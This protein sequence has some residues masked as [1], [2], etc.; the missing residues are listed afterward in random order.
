[1]SSTKN[2]NK[3]QPK[4]TIESANPDLV[5]Q[6]VN[7][8]QK[9]APKVSDNK[10]QPRKNKPQNNQRRGGQKSM[11]N[12]PKQQSDSG[13]KQN[14]PRQQAKQ[15]PRQQQK[16]QPKQQAKQQ[17]KKQ[18]QQPKQSG[19]TK[20]KQQSAKRTPAARQTRSGQS[21]SNRRRT[22]RAPKGKLKIIP[23]GGLGEVGKNLTYY[24]YGNDAFII[25]CGLAFPDDAMPGIDIVIPDF[26]YLIENQ[27]K[28]RGL[29][30]THGHEDHIG[31]IPYLLKHF[32]LPIYGTRLTIGLVEGKLKEH[33]LLRSAKLNVVKPGDSIK[34]GPMTAEFIRVNHSIPDAC[35]IAVHTPAGII[36]HT[37]DFKVDFT[38]IGGEVIDLAR[39]GELGSKGVL[40]LLSDST[41]AEREGSSSSERI[42]GGSLENFFGKAEHKRIIVATFAS[43]VH[44]IQQ[45]MDAAVKNSRKVAVSGRSME[46]VVG[47]AR[48][49]GYLNI[50]ETL[51]ID[52]DDA[53]KLPPEEVVLITT[54]S[55]GEPMSALSRMARGD[56]RKVKVTENDCIIISATPIP[57][58]EKLVTN[59]INDLLMMGADVIYDKMYDIHVS[60]HAC[61]DE[62]KMMIALTKPKFFIPVHGEYKH[63]KRH[64]E[65]ARSMGIPSENIH[66]GQNGH[67]IELDAN[68]M[69]QNTTVTSGRVLVDGL[70]IGD[71]GSIVLRD[72]K[73]LAEDGLIT[74]VATLKKGNG[75]ILA[76]PD[77][78]SRGFV[79][80][81]ESEGLIEKAEEIAK[82]ALEQSIKG[83]KRDWGALKNNIRD[84]VSDYVWQTTKRR[85]MILPIIQEV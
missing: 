28:I 69:K 72:R 54:G 39:F 70:G 60:G 48:E 7:Q 59:V 75:Q 62:L 33:G 34:F 15:Q 57:G 21:Q 2:Q 55:Q 73:H 19:E 20:A 27:K 40:A 22:P 67:V 46:N 42:V 8:K 52:V 5:N 68:S 47:K 77:I 10:N 61:Q 13:N 56:H 58:N 85:P 49:L 51:I 6:L 43:N 36:V 12:V 41:N 24:E 26:T 80:V 23:L 83:G 71:V 44:R 50:P 78:V 76:G 63:I 38:P 65:L 1:M 66:L 81:R 16:N 35:S 30:I 45:I 37:G 82:N 3:E 9:V 4:K 31:S 84:E 74:I 32:N 25:D 14:Q 17:P 53:E 29:C 64:A 11:G 18:N 79:Y